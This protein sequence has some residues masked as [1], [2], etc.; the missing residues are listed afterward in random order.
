[1]RKNRC[2]RMKKKGTKQRVFQGN[3]HNKVLKMLNRCEPRLYKPYILFNL[4]LNV[5]IYIWIILYFCRHI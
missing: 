1:M 3:T 2:K 5:Y 4:F